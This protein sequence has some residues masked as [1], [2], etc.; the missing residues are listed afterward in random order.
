MDEDS[1]IPVATNGRSRSDLV[2]RGFSRQPRIGPLAPGTGVIPYDGADQPL[3]DLIQY[4]AITV[5]GANRWL[6]TRRIS[7]QTPRSS[8][9]GRRPFVAIMGSHQSQ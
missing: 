4:S 9:L 3:S 6:V 1:F 2:E 8:N 5:R 7:A